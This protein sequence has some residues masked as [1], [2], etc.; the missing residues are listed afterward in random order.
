MNVCSHVQKIVASKTEKEVSMRNC[1]AVR[2]DYSQFKINLSL[3][4]I[5]G[6]VK[7]KLCF[8]LCAPTHREI[9]LLDFQK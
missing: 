1:L 8:S 4:V 7:E 6:T 2:G 3:M 9:W 5:K